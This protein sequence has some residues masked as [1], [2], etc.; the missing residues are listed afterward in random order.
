MVAKS[1][2]RQTL[3]RAADVLAYLGAACL[4][5]AWLPAHAGDAEDL[6]RAQ[7]HLEEGDVVRALPILR[8]LADGGFAPA[9]VKLADMLDKAEENAAAV[10]LYRKAAE[11]SNADALFGLASMTAAGE[12]VTRD[13][14]ESLRL[15]RRAAEQS[16]LPAIHAL[17]QAYIGAQPALRAGSEFA[18]EALRWSTLAAESGYLPA[19]DALANAYAK[20]D[21]GLGVDA[22]QAQAWTQRADAARRALTS[23]TASRSEKRK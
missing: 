11:Q 4:C 6:A 18:A 5:V 23:G 20:G 3:R 13:P 8:K 19:M 17:A 10:A 21:W 1:L 15:L 2:P 9:Q 7:K 22:A 16:H 14:D 12:G